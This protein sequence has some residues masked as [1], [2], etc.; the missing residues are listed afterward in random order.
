M[1]YTPLTEDQFNKAKSSGFSTE[2]IIGFEKQRNSDLQGGATSPANLQAQKNQQQAKINA[3]PAQWLPNKQNV[4]NK[5]QN[6]PDSV[7]EFQKELSTPMNPILPPQIKAAMVGAKAI[8]VP[9]QRLEAGLSSAGLS[10]QSGEFSKI[11]EQFMKGLSGQKPAELGDLIRTTGFGGGSNEM[12]SRITGL[13]PTFGIPMDAFTTINPGIKKVLNQAIQ[14]GAQV[15]KDTA[16]HLAIGKPMGDDFLKANATKLYQSA[17]TTLKAV[18]KEFGQMYSFSGIGDKP[19]DNSK[20]QNVVDKIVGAAKNESEGVLEKLKSL[21]V[22]E[23]GKPIELPAN[24][25]SAKKIQDIVQEHIPDSAWLKGKVGA[26]MTPNQQKLA[27]AYG[28]LK[29]LIY[30]S[31]DKNDAQALA[32]LDEKGSKVYRVTKAIKKMVVDETGEPVKTNQLVSMFQGKP[33][34]AGRRDLVQRLSEM[35]GS[36]NDVIQAMHQFNTRQQLKSVAKKGAG[37]LLGLT[38]LGEAYHL[39]HH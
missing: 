1:P 3:G 33:G 38:G 36:T 18:K 17:D 14:D 28:E 19:I 7:G 37:T 39:L 11:P 2:Q 16:D 9:F 10:A 24:V 15:A 30:Q 13:I 6:R 8:A 32:Q 5:I 23:K 12:L 21:I 4:E 29:G 25:S 35:N 20:L 34:Q 22:D 27:N 26:N 31:L